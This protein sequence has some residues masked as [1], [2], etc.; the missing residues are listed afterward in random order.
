MIAL[1]N[2]A[3]AFSGSAFIIASHL[4]IGPPNALVT[5]ARQPPGT[6]FT[7]AIKFSKKFSDTNFS[8][9]S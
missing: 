9:T 6:A 1:V 5:T 3:A 4:P 8:P 7:F 2:L